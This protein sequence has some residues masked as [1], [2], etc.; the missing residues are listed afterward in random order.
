MS[1][2]RIIARSML[3]IWH[4]QHRLRNAFALSSSR[5][6]LL[7]HNF[8]L[9]SLLCAVSGNL[10]YKKSRT[11]DAFDVVASM[12]STMLLFY[13]ILIPFYFSSGIY[14]SFDFEWNEIIRRRWHKNYLA[15]E[16]NMYGCSFYILDFF[17]FIYRK[18]T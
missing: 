18:L 17:F 15:S 3:L 10:G 2:Y 16:K 7:I 4:V 9:H 1:L 8:Y 13:F 6:Q 5:R 12:F 14:S 11:V